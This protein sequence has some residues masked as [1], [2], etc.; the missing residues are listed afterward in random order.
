MFVVVAKIYRLVNNQETFAAT[1]LQSGESVD[2]NV[3]RVAVMISPFL[4]NGVAGP[5]MTPACQQPIG[6]LTG[7]GRLQPVAPR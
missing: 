1:K 7:G 4:A 6:I 2:K 5:E 3:V